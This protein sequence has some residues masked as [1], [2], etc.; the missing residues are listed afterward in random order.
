[1]RKADATLVAMLAAPL[2][3]P[4]SP[5]ENHNQLCHR[6]MCTPEQVRSI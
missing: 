3:Y 1:M 4:S 2:A 5:Q 6:G